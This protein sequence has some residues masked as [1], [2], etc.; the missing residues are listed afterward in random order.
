MKQKKH[1]LVKEI[2]RVNIC[3]EETAKT[4]IQKFEEEGFQKG[5]QTEGT[6]VPAIEDAGRDFLKSFTTDGGQPFPPNSHAGK[7]L[8]G[9]YVD[10]YLEGASA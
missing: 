2:T 5:V 8:V 3:D 6:Y 7:G 10:A 1:N 4:L 9:K